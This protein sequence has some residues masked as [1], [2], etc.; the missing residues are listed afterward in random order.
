MPPSRR[1]CLALQLALALGLDPVPAMARQRPCDAPDSLGPSRDLSVRFRKIQMNRM[2][3]FR[4]SL[5]PILQ[6][7]A[8]AKP[9]QSKCCTG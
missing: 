3:Q 5:E 8:Q 7:S 2:K 4:L 6:V 1:A 9:R